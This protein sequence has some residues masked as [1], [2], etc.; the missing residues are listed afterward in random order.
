VQINKKK[1]THGLLSFINW[2]LSGSAKACGG[3][4]FAKSLAKNFK[5]LDFYK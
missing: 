5:S 1:A 3:K 2:D 4:L